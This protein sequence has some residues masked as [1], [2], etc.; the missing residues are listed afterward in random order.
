MKR[1]ITALIILS[2]ALLLSS[3]SLSS[4]P[5]RESAE[6]Q[7]PISLTLWHYYTGENQL[8][9]ESAVSAFNEGP[10]FSRGIMVTAVAKGSI[11]DLESAV[12][13]SAKG[14]IN[15]DP[16]PDIFSCYADKALELDSLGVLCSLNE[17]FSEEELS[18]FVESFI[19]D[20]TFEGGRLLVVPIAKSTELLYINATAWDEFALA[21]GADSACLSTWEGVYEAARAYYMWTDAQTPERA[22]DGR[23]FMGFDSVANYIIIGAKQLGTDIIDSEKG[24][25]VLDTQALSELFKLYVKGISLGYFD[26]VGKFRSDDIKTGDLAAFVGSS[27]SAA[28]FPTWIEADGERSDI[29]LLALPY[30]HFSSGVQLAVQQ[31]A[32]MSVTRSE[33][34]KE[35]AAAAFLQWFTDPEQNISFSMTS[36]Y[37]PVKSA[38]YNDDKFDSLMASLRDGDSSE[39]NIA[40]VNL[41][42]L[43]Q[44]VSNETYAARPFEGSYSARPVLQSSL[45][46]AALAAKVHAEALKNSGASE[47]AIVE[48]LEL[49]SR[50]EKWLL[51]LGDELNLDER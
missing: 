14:L 28:Y 20:G 4:G 21:E 47:D 30:P 35:A 1:K 8:A 41:I 29:A 24:T 6:P 18:S 40:E 17:Y 33:P 7:A 13:D 26:A 2:A 38:S 11:A 16:L 25:I 19:D 50:F 49:D 9:L 42:A 27:S 34:E 39:R 51:A 46:E 10:G 3:C 36:G 44:I 22:W 32:G 45:I 5:G 15:A 43:N 23:A 12:T 37:L 31:G 48:A